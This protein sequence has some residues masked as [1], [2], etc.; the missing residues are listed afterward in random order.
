LN[1][2]R[3]FSVF[4]KE[5]WHITRDRVTFFLVTL[6]PA[7]VLISMGAAFSVEIRDVSISV[8][9]QDRSVLSRRYQAHLQTVGDVR[10]DGEAQ[11]WEEVERGII[12]GRYKGAVVI[13]PGFEK[14]IVAGRGADVQVIVDGTDPSTAEHAI[15][16]I[17]G[18]TQAFALDLAGKLLARSGA[19]P[20][21]LAPPVELRTRTL[22][23]PSLKYTIG[24]IPALLA[25]SLTMPAIA[26]SLAISREHEWGTMEMLITT[27]IGRAEL[28]LGKLLPYILSG[29]LSTVLCVGV[30][31]YLFDVPL[32]G[33]LGLFM[34][35]SADFLW[36]SLSIGLLLSV[37]VRSQQVAMIGA[38]LLFLFP[39]FFLSGIFIPLSSM[40]I[41]KLE[42]YLM[43]TTHYVLISRGIFLKGVGMAALWPYA[44]AL[45]G[46]GLAMS[47][48]AI[49]VFQK[50]LS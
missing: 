29:L 50:R 8:L 4:R 48:F 46:M 17:L 36:A 7:L 21:A 1:L 2:R 39:G 40:G 37:L 42:A 9:D 41:M 47:F 16:H 19:P 24:M 34:L 28:V 3:T 31:R 23:N 14:A 27:P 33:S 15:T 45:F 43:P 44:A 5:L 32:R 26:A 35:L 18:R 10:I 13:P 30:A 11:N 49:L 25:V 38:F 20:E 22:Y 12:G 6:S